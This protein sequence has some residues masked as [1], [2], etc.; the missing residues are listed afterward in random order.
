MDESIERLSHCF[1]E[2][3]IGSNI[4]YLPET[5][6]TNQVA[7][8]IPRGQAQHGTVI[9]TSFQTAGRGRQGRRWFSIPDKGIFLTIILNVDDYLRSIIPLC[10][11]VAAKSISDTL[12][13]LGLE[14]DIKWP[15]DVLVNSKKISGVLGEMK[16]GAKGIERI[17]LGMSLNLNHNHRDFPEEIEHLATSV[18][19]ETGEEPDTADV[20]LNLL[21]EHNHWFNQLKTRGEP[22][23]LKEV[24]AASSMCNGKEISFLEPGGIL[25]K[26]T[27]AGLAP[28][29]NLQIILANG[30]S[31]TIH[32]G[33]VHLHRVG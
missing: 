20:L 31:K 10:S 19:L 4:I 23:F 6:S 29:G 11:L 18:L 16:T 32:A 33:D 26:G 24:E 7:L 8:Q 15:N 13:L 22:A 17:A 25:Q 1:S 9:I 2:G 12:K 28:G 14:A 27:T 3:E 21:K 30:S 5:S